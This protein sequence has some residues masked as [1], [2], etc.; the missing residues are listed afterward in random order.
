MNSPSSAAPTETAL[1][2]TVP[3]VVLSDPSTQT[4][5]GYEDAAP[6][7][8]HE[9]PHTEPSDVPA[10]IGATIGA[11]VLVAVI[12]LLF[13]WYRKR[14]RRRSHG[15]REVQKRGADHVI[16]PSGK[17]CGCTRS[18]GYDTDVYRLQT[19]WAI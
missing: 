3:S 19:D 9:P 12:S 2:D 16:S 4:L 15:R 1:G 17:T 5:T 18:N 7:E 11:L 6:D 10:I 13:F 14:G 8:P